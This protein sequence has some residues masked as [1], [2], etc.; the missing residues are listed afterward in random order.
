[1]TYCISEIHLLSGYT[2]PKK[3]LLKRAGETLQIRVNPHNILIIFSFLFYNRAIAATLRGGV[4]ALVCK[5]CQSHCTLAG[6]QPCSKH[7]GVEAW[8]YHRWLRLQKL[9]PD[10]RYFPALS[11]G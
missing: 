10:G 5:L 11:A 3:E 9:A 4:K 8:S 2:R 7:L 6:T 1:M